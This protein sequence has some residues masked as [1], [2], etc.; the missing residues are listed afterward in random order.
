MPKHGAAG[1]RRSAARR[2]RKRRIGRAGRFTMWRRTGKSVVLGNDGLGSPSYGGTTDWE[3]RRTG[4]RRTGK[5]VVRRS[6]GLGSPSYGRAT[7]WEVRRTAE[8]RTGKSVV[9]GSC[10]TSKLVIRVATT[11]EPLPGHSRTCTFSRCCT[12]MGRSVPAP[13]IFPRATSLADA[14]AN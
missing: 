13:R 9:R 14:A 4:E 12:G 3:V 11:S 2:I 10:A 7:D 5:S 6:D 8:R 1:C